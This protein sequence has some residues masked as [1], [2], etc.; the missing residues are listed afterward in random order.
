[1]YKIKMLLNFSSTN[2]NSNDKVELLLALTF[3]IRYQVQGPGME[4]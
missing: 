2:L 4:Q 1:M 3:S